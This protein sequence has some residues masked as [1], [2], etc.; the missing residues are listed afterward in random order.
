MYPETFEPLDLYWPALARRIERVAFRCE[1]AWGLGADLHAKAL[2][3]L[4]VVG[5]ML[6]I[7]GPVANA[8]CW[9]PRS[10][11]PTEAASAR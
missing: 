3:H 9:L 6:L 8:R 11:E 7:H 2:I 1:S 5:A 10:N 4:I